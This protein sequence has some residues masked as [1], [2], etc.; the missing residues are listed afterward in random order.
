VR[1][2][3]TAGAASS[4]QR[5]VAFPDSASRAGNA[6]R[7]GASRPVD[8]RR[9]AE[10]AP[11]TYECAEDG[12][13]LTGLVRDELAEQVPV[14]Y[15]RGGLRPFRVIVTCPGGGAPHQVSCSGQVRYAR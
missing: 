5:P 4:G 14:A 13:D 6:L 2:S 10:L 3:A 7:V 8:V 9:V 1:S 11:T 15:H 12:Q